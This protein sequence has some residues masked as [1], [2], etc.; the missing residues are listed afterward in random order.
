VGEHITFDRIGGVRYTEKNT[1][2]LSSFYFYWRKTMFVIEVDMARW[3]LWLVING[4]L[5]FKFLPY[6]LTIDEGESPSL[7][8]HAFF[9]LGIAVIGISVVAFIGVTT[10]FLGL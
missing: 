7:A 9:W 4:L 3:L 6:L 1:H 5:L 8:R 2:H 10:A